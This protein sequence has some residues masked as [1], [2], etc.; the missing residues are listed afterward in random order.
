LPMMGT[1]GWVWG[2]MV[3]PGLMTWSAGGLGAIVM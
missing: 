1:D 2:L 3:L